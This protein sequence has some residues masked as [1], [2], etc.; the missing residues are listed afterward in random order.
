MHIQKKKKKLSSYLK[1]G[2]KPKS[3]TLHFITSQ[4]YN[5]PTS[6]NC[7]SLEK[8]SSMANKREDIHDHDDELSSVEEGNP[9]VMQLCCSSN[10][11]I[12]L[13]QKVSVT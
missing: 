8:L 10:N 7:Y 12:T 1:T 13:I 11:A 9:N 4:Y 2:P 6:R 3:T 5:S